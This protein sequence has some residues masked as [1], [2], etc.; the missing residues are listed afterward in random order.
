[1]LRKHR[2]LANARELTQRLRALP[3]GGG[4]EIAEYVVFPHT[5]HAMAAWPALARGIPFAFPER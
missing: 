1:M 5:D 3:R 4:F 2:M